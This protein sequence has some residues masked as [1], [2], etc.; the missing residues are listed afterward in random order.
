MLI[1]HKCGHEL[2]LSKIYED[3]SG[4]YQFVLPCKKHIKMRI[5]D[6]DENGEDMIAMRRINSLEFMEEF[7]KLVKER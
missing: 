5:L 1:C 4:K 6:L 2:E 3:N 7:E